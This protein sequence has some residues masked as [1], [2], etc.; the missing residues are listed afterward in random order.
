MLEIKMNKLEFDIYYKPTQTFAYLHFHSSHPRHIKRRVPYT[1]AT[2]INTI[3]SK[4][5][6]GQKCLLEMQQQLRR[7]KY[8]SRLIK[9][10]IESR[11]G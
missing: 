5:T 7:R 11:A 3:V 8:P 9:D 2:M 1:L 4:E 10:A 6:V